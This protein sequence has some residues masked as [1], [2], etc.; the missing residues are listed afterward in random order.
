MTDNI[1]NNGGA[2]TGSG[3]AL[4]AVDSPDE[5]ADFAEEL[6]IDDLEEDLLRSTMMTRAGTA[7]WALAR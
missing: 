5:Q 2:D 4:I 1:T 3:S 7:F 6:E